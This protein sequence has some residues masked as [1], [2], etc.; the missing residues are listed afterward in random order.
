MAP[1]EM[2]NTTA[3]Y[4][5]VFLMVMSCLLLVYM[6]VTLLFTIRYGEE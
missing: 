1:I 3:I 5:G 4:C 6:L 2:L